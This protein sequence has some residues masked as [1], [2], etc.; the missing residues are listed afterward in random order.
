MSNTDKRKMQKELDELINTLIVVMVTEGSLLGKLL[1][2]PTPQDIVMEIEDAYP[3]SVVS[4]PALDQLGRPMQNEFGL[5]AMMRVPKL[6][7]LH[8]CKLESLAKIYVPRDTIHYFVRDQSRD[9]QET[10]AS[11]YQNFAQELLR[12]KNKEPETLITQATPAEVGAVAQK[13]AAVNRI[14]RG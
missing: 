1:R 10:F 6:S 3:I 14:T 2:A 13:A 12:V 7:T 11:V 5:P 9:S 4:V 8:W